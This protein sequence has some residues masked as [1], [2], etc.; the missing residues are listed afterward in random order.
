MK[1]GGSEDWEIPEVGVAEK[2]LNGETELGPARGGGGGNGNGRG[3]YGDRGRSPPRYDRDRDYHNNGGRDYR[4]RSRDRDRGRDGYDDDRG[5]SLSRS[6]GRNGGD[7]RDQDEIQVLLEKRE[8]YRYRREFD[9]ADPIRDEM[10][11][12]GVIL[13]D[14]DFRW[15]SRDGRM[16]GFIAQARDLEHKYPDL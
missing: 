12:R 14:A 16:G 6:P 8:I 2:V 9:K 15:E 3:D 7:D 10:R 13:M 4:S 1:G 11:H 5:R